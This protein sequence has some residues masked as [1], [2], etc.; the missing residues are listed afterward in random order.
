MF[1]LYPPVWSWTAAA[2]NDDVLCR[3]DSLIILDI[4]LE[5]CPFLMA[6]VAARL[7]PNLVSLIAQPRHL[8]SNMGSS[9]HG[10]HKPTTTTSLIVNPNSRLSTQKW[11]VRVLHRLAVFFDA[12]VIHSSQALVSN[13]SASLLPI[14]MVT[15]TA[16]SHHCIE[17]SA[18]VTQSSLH[19]FL[20]RSLFQSFYTSVDIIV[21]TSHYCHVSHACGPADATAT[22]SSLL[23]SIMVCPSGSGLLR[24]PG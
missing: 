9:Q 7:L 1:R 14:V 11:R 24:F 22:P 16:A 8:T 23:N 4:L 5:R 17:S 6:G 19:H 18:H 20:L 12:V 10:G 2:S 15:D 21:I 13:E 3:L